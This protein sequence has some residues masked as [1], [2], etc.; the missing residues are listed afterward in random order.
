MALKGQSQALKIFSRRVVKFPSVFYPWLKSFLELSFAFPFSLQWDPK[1]FIQPSI[2]FDQLLQ[3]AFK[4]F[5]FRNQGGEACV[6]SG[7]IA[8]MSAGFE[9]ARNSPSKLLRPCRQRT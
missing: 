1:H 3:L 4:L 8:G 2:C 7:Q 6:Q 9:A 5:H